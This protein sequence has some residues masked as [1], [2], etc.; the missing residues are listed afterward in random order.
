MK[1]FKWFT[2]VFMSIVLFFSSIFGFSSGAGQKHDDTPEV[3]E[4]PVRAEKLIYGVCHPDE[5]YE[6]LKGAGLDWVRF[7]IPYPYDADGNISASYAAFKERA[8]G[9]REQGIKVLAITPYP[10]YYFKKGEGS[11]ALGVVAQRTKEVAAFLCND[12]KDIVAGFQ[13]TNEMGV[14]SFR[15]PLTLEQAAKFIG[16]QAQVMA[17]RKGDLIIGYNSAGIGE[18]LHKLVE[19]YLSYMDFVGVDLYYGTLGAGSLQDFVSGIQKVHEL[20]QKPIILAEFGY[21]SAGEPK[22]AQERAAV[23]ARYGY[24]S[25]EEARADIE[26]FVSKL[27]DALKAQVY[28]GYPD[29]ATWGD[30][31]FQDMATH[32]YG[33][34]DCAISGIPHTPQ[35]QAEFYRQLLP[36]LKKINCLAGFFVFCWKDAGVC[37]YCGQTDCPYKSAWG[38]TDANGAPKP[39]YDAVKEALAT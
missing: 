9:Y 2:S 29:P 33:Y 31:V 36:L 19:P 30:A 16:V 5:N 1:V 21:A 17:G 38:I 22:S 10:K 34:I 37:K 24:A 15:Y 8:R 13:I 39:A 27:P 14:S 23:L 6:L 20:T 18:N 28:N 7:D 3:P 12:L 11:S 26:N 25:E 35:G 32:F 4:Q